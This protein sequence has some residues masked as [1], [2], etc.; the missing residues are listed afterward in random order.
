[1]SGGFTQADIRRAVEV[2]VME[3]EWAWRHICTLFL[4]VSCFSKGK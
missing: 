4:T 1:M 3:E 2:R